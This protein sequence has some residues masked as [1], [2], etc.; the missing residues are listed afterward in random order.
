MLS[1]ITP[2]RGLV[3]LFGL[4]VIAARHPRPSATEWHVGEVERS[5]IELT[6]DGGTFVLHRRVGSRC[7]DS[8]LT[9]HFYGA[10]SPTVCGG[11]TVVVHGESTSHRELEAS[12]VSGFN[13][14]KYDGCW[15][16]R[17]DAAAYERCRGRSGLSKF[18]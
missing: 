8:R 9:V 18:E 2:L 7:A 4:T 16:L 14:G 13:D 15:Q 6:D 1:L 12:R 10:L 5:S 17:C 11:M 3:V